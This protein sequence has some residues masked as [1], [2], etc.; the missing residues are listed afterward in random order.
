MNHFTDLKGFNAIRAVSPWRFRAHRQRNKQPFGAYFT[1]L[2]LSAPNFFRKVRIP[3]KKQ[4][5]V[6]RFVDVGD[7]LSFPGVRGRYVF[8]APTDYF[9]AKPRQQYEGPA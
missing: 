3:V 7:L 5:F 1:T 6:F 9:V 2:G 8:Y 4:R